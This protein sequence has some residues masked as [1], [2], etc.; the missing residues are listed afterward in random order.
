MGIFVSQ[1]PERIVEIEKEFEG[2]KSHFNLLEE[3][4]I[5]TKLGVKDKEL[6]LGKK[7]GEIAKLDGQL[8][9]MKTNKEYTAMLEQIAGI[10]ADKGMLEEKILLDWDNVEKLNKEKEEEK[11]RLA[12]D[13]MKANQQKKVLEEDGRRAEEKIRQ[14]KEE[15]INILTPVTHEIK[16]LYEKIL[17]K[18]EGVALVKI[19]GE[20]CG[21]CQ[22]L[23]RPQIINEVRLQENIT[24]CERCTRILYYE[25]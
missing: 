24:L 4:I 12:G 10:K 25:A 20:N 6:E 18:R 22:F 17:A 7:D 23:L 11:K 2:K 16:D 5:K 15:R 9:Q 3:E 19:D 1:I 14:L 13:E 21:G 8:A